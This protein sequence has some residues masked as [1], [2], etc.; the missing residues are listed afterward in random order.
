ME[1]GTDK[2][3][4]CFPRPIAAI[5]DSADAAEEGVNVRRWRS[6]LEGAQY[7]T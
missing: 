2:V 1:Q 6:K 4:P 7:M 5:P 3:G